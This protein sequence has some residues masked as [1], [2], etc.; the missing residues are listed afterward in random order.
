LIDIIWI[1]REATTL[2]KEDQNQNSWIVSV[3]ISQTTSGR[4]FFRAAE[5]PVRE[6]YMPFAEPGKS[7][8]GL[9]LSILIS[10]F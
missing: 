3:G 5:G 2:W 10:D 1:Q 8:F 7:L 6:E 9:L 4:R